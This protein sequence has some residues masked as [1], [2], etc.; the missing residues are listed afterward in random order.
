M[1]INRNFMHCIQN[2]LRDAG[3]HSNA[4]QIAIK[5]IKKV[6]NLITNFFGDLQGLDAAER[7]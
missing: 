1:Q 2:L 3:N 6:Q 4:S 5:H 7:E